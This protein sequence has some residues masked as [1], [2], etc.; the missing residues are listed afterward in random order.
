MHFIVSSKIVQD[1]ITIVYEK[2]HLAYLDIDYER[3]INIKY[4]LKETDNDEELQPSLTDNVSNENND[5]LVMHRNLPSHDIIDERL[6]NNESITVDFHFSIADRKETSDDTLTGLHV[7]T[8]LLLASEFH[9]VLDFCQN[10]SVKVETISIQSDRNKT[11]EEFC[12]DP[13]VMATT[14]D[15][16]IR[17]RIRSD[18]E[19]DYVV[20][21]PSL[22]T[23]YEIG[24]YTYLFMVQALPQQQTVIFYF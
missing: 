1:K 10:Y 9:A 18:G 13:D 7:V 4:E 16:I 15:G 8:L 12:D 14:N 21:V 24:D 19:I 3:I 17:R 5:T 2:F 23:T 22:E 20:D 6:S 11:Q